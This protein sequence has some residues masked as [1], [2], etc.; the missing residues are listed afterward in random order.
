MRL[1][2]AAAAALAASLLAGCALGPT[3]PGGFRFAVLGDTPYNER[4]EKA[5]VAMIARIDEAP[6]AFAIHVGDFKGGSH[7][8]CTDAVYVERKAEL[9]RSRHP[10]V[11]TPG[12]NDWTDCRRRSNGAM[13]PIERLARLREIFF[14]TPASLGREPMATIMQSGC[15]AP[16]RP[17]C[18]CAAHPE[19]RRWT[20]GGV[21]FVTINVPGSN[22][23][24]GHDAANDREALCRGEANRRWLEG[25]ASQV[26]RAQGLGLVI[27]LQADPWSSHRPAVYRALLEQVAA[28]G[29]RLARPVLFVHGDTH[30][31]KFDRPFTDASG[32]AID[33]I[34]RLETYGSPLVGWV[35]VAV[36]PGDPHLFRV[37]P[38]F[39]A[40]VP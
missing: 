23:N 31:Y 14:A 3:A 16:P 36:D 15:L 29:R 20:R 12:D 7:A 25:A 11:L 32:A 33:D 34:M 6:V 10:V 17:E 1:R 22:D 38:H 28:I 24:V 35:E 18:G 19:N 27:A 8:P 13:D 5:F 26:V 30:T 39:E 2:A 21:T 4:E 9:D 37:E 40:I